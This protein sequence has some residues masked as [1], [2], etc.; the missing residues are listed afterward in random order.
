MVSYP[1]SASSSD[2]NVYDCEFGIDG[3]TVLKEN[4]FLNVISKFTKIY[5][6]VEDSHSDSIENS[7]V[8]RLNK[9]ME[10]SRMCAI[11]NSQPNPTPPGNTELRV[12]AILPDATSPA[13]IKVS[14]SK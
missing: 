3:P 5:M 8:G 13:L 4:I 10:G 14:N 1:S 2:V 11:D 12:H 9:L 6:E 7:C